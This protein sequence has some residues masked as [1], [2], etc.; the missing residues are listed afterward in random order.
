MKTRAQILVIAAILLSLGLLLLAVSVDA[1]RLYL[2]RLNLERSAQAAAD[3]GI[4]VAAEQVVTL[5]A[6]RQTEAALAPPC[7]ATPPA[8]CTPTPP[9]NELEAWLNEDDR[10]ALVAAAVQAEVEDAALAYAERNG[11]AREST[12]VD[13][14]FGYHPDDATVRVRVRTSRDLAILLAGL[15]SPDWVHLEA[16]AISQVPQR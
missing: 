15:L 2:E 9:P 4:G 5:A 10:E 14:P 12:F 13:Y 3:A 6:A 1:G 8:V 16:A 11:L 7:A